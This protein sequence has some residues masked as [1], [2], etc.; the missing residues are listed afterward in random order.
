[1]LTWKRVG[2]SSFTNFTPIVICGDLAPITPIDPSNAEPG[3]TI[4]CS[5]SGSGFPTDSAQTA[6]PSPPTT[7]TLFPIS[8]KTLNDRPVTLSLKLKLARRLGIILPGEPG[9]VA[10]QKNF[11][12][13]R[14]VC[15]TQITL[16]PSL[17]GTW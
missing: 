14:A 11:W 10:N 6:L 16:K 3:F 1:L 5:S 8:T 4:T 7:T 15:E 17:T 13:A 12:W 9:Y 2:Y